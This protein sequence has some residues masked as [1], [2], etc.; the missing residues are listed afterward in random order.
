MSVLS[1]HHLTTA[2]DTARGRALAVDRVDLDLGAGETLAVVGE[3]GCGKTMLA[4]SLLRLVPAPPARITG[5]RVEFKGRDLLGLSQAQMR[6]VRGEGISMIFQEPMTSLNPVFKVGDQVDEALAR[7]TGLSRSRRRERVL[8]LFARVGIPNPDERVH[9]YPH[10]LSGGMRQRVMI[11]MALALDPDVI[12]ADEPTT[13]L[14]VT[15]QAEIM[16]LLRRLQSRRSTSVMLITHDLGVVAETCDRVMV[17]YA[18][19]VVEEA[20]VFDFFADPGHP[21][22]RGLLASVPRLDAAKDG[23]S[24]ISGNVPELLALPAGCPFHPRCPHRFAPCD[25]ESPPMF[26]R[27]QG[28][29]RCWLFA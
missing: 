4:L 8:D 1:A 5:G 7:H 22:S 23:L 29:A 15:I 10:Q 16:A 3:S 6:S 17:M 9:A 18:G 25:R 13:A 24:P 11:A 21:Y 2:L 26:D 19:R 20:G 28:R 14:D 27:G 12:L